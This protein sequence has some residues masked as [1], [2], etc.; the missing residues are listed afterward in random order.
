MQDS[1]W[2][3]G[4]LVFLL[5]VLCFGCT[6]QI[7]NQLTR[8]DLSLQ[9]DV[10][11][12]DGMSEFLID[13]TEFDEKYTSMIDPADF[14]PEIDNPFL[15]L[16]PGTTFIYEGETEEGLER[17]EVNVTRKTK[18]ILGVNCTGVR[19]RIW[20]DDKLKDRDWRNNEWTEDTLAWYAQDEDGNVWYFGEDSKDIEGGVVVST[21]DS[22]EAG[23]N[24]AKP[25]IVMKGTP[26]V[27]DVYRQSY[28]EGVAEDMDRV[29]SL[30]ESVDVP[31]GSFQNCLK[32]ME[33]TPLEPDVIEHK[34]YAPGLGFI[35]K[36]EVEAGAVSGALVE[37]RRE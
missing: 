33:W 12:I 37:V 13:P 7:P 27:G 8:D 19:D 20:L 18:I 2:L 25:G 34:F 36:V 16:T 32:T 29:L 14:V 10:L 17:T 1:D 24:G 30:N 21:A 9:S 11:Q 15:P 35:L 5:C 26:K 28:A 6:D 3:M 4:F 23:V 31:V 22:W